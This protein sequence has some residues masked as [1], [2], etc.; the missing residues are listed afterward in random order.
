MEGA[1]VTVGEV[2]VCGQSL[3]LSALH[4][5][6]FE[7]HIRDLEEGLASCEAQLEQRAV[8]P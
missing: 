3:T 5:P 8:A 4:G 6:S 1:V 7:A 2:E